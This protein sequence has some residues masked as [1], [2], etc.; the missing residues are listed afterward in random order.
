MTPAIIFLPVSTSPGNNLL[1]VTAPLAKTYRQY[2]DNGDET[3][4]TI[5]AS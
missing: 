1:P 2:N 3:V 5:S 4:A